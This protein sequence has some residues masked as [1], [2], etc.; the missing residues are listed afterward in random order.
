MTSNEEVARMIFD[1]EE[2]EEVSFRSGG[3]EIEN[4]G[5]VSI[6]LRFANIEDMMMF[7][8]DLIPK[9][10]IRV[11]DALD[12]GFIVTGREFIVQMNVPEELRVTRHITKEE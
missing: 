5:P 4:E 9:A 1:A 6:T 8:D 2:N 3:K 12:D 11:R 10:G 7:R